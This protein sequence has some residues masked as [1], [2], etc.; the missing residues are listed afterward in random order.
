MG[1]VS[2]DQVNISW[3]VP[4]LK[5]SYAKVNEEPEELWDQYDCNIL[6][7]GWTDRMC[8]NMMNLCVHSKNGTSFIE[9]VEDSASPHTRKYIFKWVEDCTGKHQVLQ[10]A[11]D[12][13]ANI[14]AKNMIALT[15][16]HYFGVV[17]QPTSTRM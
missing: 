1:E 14:A 9:Y 11:I 4:L 10:F 5:Q 6:I 3:R 13:A 8:H 16:P 15:R 17:V 12:N 2:R 7:D